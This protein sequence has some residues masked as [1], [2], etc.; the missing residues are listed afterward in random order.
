MKIFL[1]GTPLHALYV[2]LYIKSNNP[3]PTTRTYNRI[4]FWVP[5]STVQYSVVVMHL[6]SNGNVKGDRSSRFRL[7]TF[8]YNQLLN[9]RMK[10]QRLRAY[11]TASQQLLD[12]RPWKSLARWH[13]L[14]YVGPLKAICPT[15]L[16]VLQL[17]N[18]I[19]MHTHI[20][21]GV[22]VKAA[23][24][25]E[26]FIYEQCNILFHFTIRYAIHKSQCAIESVVYAAL[27]GRDTDQGETGKTEIQNKSNVIC[28]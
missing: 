14:R 1:L 3:D 23:S 17:Y 16:C 15:A 24:E 10:G 5:E 27:T 28:M 12:L 2:L 25:S 7:I 22:Q 19:F 6:R 11:N 20:S 8:H 26:R 18:Q 21:P 9:C 13:Q 4:A